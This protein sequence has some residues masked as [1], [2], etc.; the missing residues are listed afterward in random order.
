MLVLGFIISSIS[1]YYSYRYYDII[2]NGAKH[3]ATVTEIIREGSEQGYKY[4]IE[5]EYT[6]DGVT[7]TYVPSYR[8]GHQ[9]HKEG[10]TLTLYQS[11]RGL[12]LIEFYALLGVALGVL[13][14]LIFFIGGLMWM[15]KHIRRYDTVERLKRNGKK[16]TARYI[17]GEE[18]SYEINNLPGMVL[19][20]K[21]ENGEQIFRTHPIFSVFSIKWLEEHIFDVYVDP[22]NPHEYYVD[23]EKHFG[24]PAK[25]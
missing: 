2:T 4:G 24:E 22:K 16:V 21:Q 19:Y 18:T 1:L 13:F 7:R 9:T 25:Y 12:V 5:V 8:I 23:L 15:L 10:D 20:F 14:G 17:R 11:N 3:Q 6:I